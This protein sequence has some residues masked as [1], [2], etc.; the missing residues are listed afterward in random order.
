WQ[1][2][3]DVHLVLV[4]IN[5]DVVPGAVALDRGLAEVERAAQVKRRTVARAVDSGHPGPQWFPAIEEPESR[6]RGFQLD[7]SPGTERGGGRLR[8]GR[9]GWQRSLSWYFGRVGWWWRGHQ[10][11]LS[12]KGGQNR[13]GCAVSIHV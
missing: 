8:R 3:G 11:S 6:H 7:Y 5:E 4:V 13:G 12:R 2:V 1:L 10:S 9:R